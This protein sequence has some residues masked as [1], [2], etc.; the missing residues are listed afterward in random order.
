[1]SEITAQYGKKD[2]FLPH[3]AILKICFPTNESTWVVVVLALNTSMLP[4]K[5]YRMLFIA[6]SAILI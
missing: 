4:Q 1:V 5:I 6:Y 3:L 2:E